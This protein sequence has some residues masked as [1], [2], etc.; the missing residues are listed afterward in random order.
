MESRGDEIAAN[1][2]N[3]REEVTSTFRANNDQ[4]NNQTEL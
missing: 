1:E 3:D 4:S 2:M